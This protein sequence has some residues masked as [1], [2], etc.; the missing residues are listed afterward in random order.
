ME[1]FKNFLQLLRLSHWSKSIFVLLG[2]FYS[3]DGKF[4]VPALLAALAFCLISSAVYIYNDIEDRTEDRLH[5]HKRH[6]PLAAKK[7]SQTD[8]FLIMFV[9]LIIGLSLGWLVSKPL[10]VLLSI[11]LLV[12]VAYN[13]GLKVIPLLDVSCIAIGFMLRV[14]AGTVGIGLPISGWLTVTATLLSL[15]IALNKR[16][17][18]LQ[19]GLTHSTRKVL[20]NYHPQLLYWAILSTGFGCFLTYLFYSIYAHTESFYFI[21]TLPFAAIALWRFAWLTTRNIEND[22]PINV[23]LNDRLSRVNLYCFITLTLL[24]LTK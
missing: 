12:N 10:A 20:T 18:E 2:L 9:L 22:D 14:L 5:P 19:L 11:Y 4:L 13:H 6:R 7:V 24:A 23:F 17:L 3:Q 8:A 21:L 15:F 16:R 1:P